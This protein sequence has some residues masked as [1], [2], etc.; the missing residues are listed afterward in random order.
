MKII[1]EPINKD[2]ILEKHNHFF[3]TMIKAVADTERKILAIDGELHADLEGFLMEQGSSQENLWGINLYLQKEKNDWIEYT[4]LINIR[5][6][7]KNEQMEVENPET[8]NTIRT[9]V[10]TLIVP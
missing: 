10:Y 8:R 1:S 6:A 2:E 4:A 5:P 9:I 7:M 3:S